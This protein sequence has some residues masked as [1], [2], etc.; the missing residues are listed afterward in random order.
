MITL[1]FNNTGLRLLMGLRLSNLEKLLQNS[2]SQ[3]QIINFFLTLL[4][5][6]RLKTGTEQWIKKIA[7]PKGISD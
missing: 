4:F 2:I 6:V 7:L 3:K 1:T 5:Q